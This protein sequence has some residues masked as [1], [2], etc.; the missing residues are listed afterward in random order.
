MSNGNVGQKK[1]LH[2]LVWVGIGCAGLVI[3][4]FIAIAG[5]GLFAAK[6]VAEVAEDVAKDP[7]KAAEWVIKANPELELVETDREAGTMTIR[8]KDTGET[9][10][11]DYSDIREGKISF[12]GD[13]GSFRVD[14]TGATIETKEGVTRYGSNPEAVPDWVTLHPAKTE[15]NVGMTAE[16]PNGKSGMVQIKIPEAPA[17]VADYYVETFGDEGFE[18]ENRINSEGTQGVQVILG[19]RHADGRKVQ[20]MIVG[21]DGGSQATLTYEEPAG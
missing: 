3:I 15:A 16:T 17:A 4:G 21:Q 14:S 8:K 11:V 9:M 19:L 6:K 7:A 12:E 10:T 5:L 2:P 18:V 20:L 13:E 1:G